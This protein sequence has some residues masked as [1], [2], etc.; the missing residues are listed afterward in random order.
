MSNIPQKPVPG[1]KYRHYKNQKIY[2][3][4]V[5]ALHSET[6][7]EMV[8]YHNSENQH[9]VRPLDLFIGFVQTEKGLVRRFTKEQ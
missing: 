3:V 1:E 6:D 4:V 8:V 7:E 5:N 9:F 2:T